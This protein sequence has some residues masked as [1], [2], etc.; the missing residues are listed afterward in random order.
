MIFFKIKLSLDDFESKFTFH[1]VED[2]PP[3]EEF[4]PCKKIYPSQEARS[5]S[6]FLSQCDMK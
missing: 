1:S 3:P 6:T 4:K 5:K 2:F